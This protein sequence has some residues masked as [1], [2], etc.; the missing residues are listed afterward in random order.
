MRRVDRSSVPQGVPPTVQDLMRISGGTAIELNV[1]KISGVY[2]LSAADLVLYVGQSIDV[3][4]R[5]SAHR[6]RR[7]FAWDRSFLI[8]YPIE[9]LERWEQ[10]WIDTLRPEFNIDLGTL[11][12]RGLTYTDY[13]ADGTLLPPDAKQQCVAIEEHRRRKKLF[14][15][16]RSEEEFLRSMR[17]G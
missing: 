11:K 9:Q 8:T 12:R 15:Q 16:R 1:P 4:S 14:K 5:I 13:Q 7:D 10:H 3:Y 6:N 17:N 2:F